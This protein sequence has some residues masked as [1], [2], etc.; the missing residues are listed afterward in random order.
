[1][2]R[3]FDAV[4]SL[5]GVRHEVDYEA[6]AAMELE[7]HAREETAA[8]KYT[9]EIGPQGTVDVA[10]VIRAVVADVREEVATAEIAAGFHA[11]VARLIAALAERARAETGLT[12][13]ALG[14][15]VFQNVVLLE[16][17]QARLGE[18]GFTV[19]RPRLLPPGDGGLALGQLLISCL[20]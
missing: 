17:A 15:G 4:A 14:G 2:G 5:A 12:V 8:S 13:V 6:Q 11:A 20:A 10:G 9:F 18:R 7:R 19:L 16:A 3:L 1:M